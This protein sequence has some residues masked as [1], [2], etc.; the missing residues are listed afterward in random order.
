MSTD[1]LVIAGLASEILERHGFVACGRR[2]NGVARVDFWTRGGGM[3]YRHELTG[4]DLTVDEVVAACL[5]VAG[6]TECVPQARRTSHL[7]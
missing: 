5:S 4:D 2:E 7:S 6:H 3:A 1:L